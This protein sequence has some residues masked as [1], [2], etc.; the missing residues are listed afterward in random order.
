MSYSA[1]QIGPPIP[2]VSC[3]QV[4][5]LRLQ[6][7][8]GSGG[9]ARRAL[10]AAAGGG[11]QEDRGGVGTRRDG[12]LHAGAGNPT[13]ETWPDTSSAAGPTKMLADVLPSA[14]ANGWR[15]LRSGCG[16]VKKT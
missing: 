5:L 11:G 1:C 7:G 16:P 8:Q 6:Q 9:S 3:W 4:L 14:V 10:L 13:S 12:G 2:I 15:L